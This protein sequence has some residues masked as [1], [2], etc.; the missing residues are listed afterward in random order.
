MVV[1][2][3]FLKKDFIISYPEFC[4]HVELDRLK[5]S[6]A[7]LLGDSIVRACG[8]VPKVPHEYWQIL[9]ILIDYLLES[10]PKILLINLSFPWLA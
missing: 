1:K 10:Q 6:K 5:P 8:L 4:W 7:G 9:S 2:G 3:D